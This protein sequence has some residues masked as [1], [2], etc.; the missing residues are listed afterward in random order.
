[1]NDLGE[2]HFKMIG[3]TLTEI[4]KKEISIFLVVFTTALHVTHIGI[5]SA[6]TMPMELYKN[7][8]IC[9]YIH[10]HTQV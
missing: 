9:I 1:M 10:T 2:R 8:Y 3:E 4:F 7:K 6:R 5:K